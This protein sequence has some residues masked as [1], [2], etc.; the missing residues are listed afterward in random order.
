[1]ETQ[2]AVLLVTINLV[3]AA[4]LT[5][6]LARGRA[7]QCWS[8]VAYLC[9]ILTCDTLVWVAPER[10]YTVA[11]WGAKQALFDV[12]RTAVALEMTWRVV[13]AFPGALQVARRSALVLLVGG[14]L[15]LA[16][17][18]RQARLH[19]LVGW[20]PRVVACT[21]LLF[22][23]T[24]LLVA[25]YHLPIRRLHRVIMGGFAI[26]SVFFATALSLMTRSGFDHRVWLNLIDALAYLGVCIAWLRA[27][28]A[29]AEEVMPE[30]E[31]IRVMVE[32]AA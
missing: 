18:P 26:Y 4:T 3:I 8:F 19:D 29:R 32:K 22:T 15:A 11:F 20:Q 10:Y 31:E 14:S 17:A 23:L 7:S 24:A 6:L 1:M 12:L 27:A 21:A 2:Q 28:W 30:V 5:G 16:G 13:R 9:G 25:W